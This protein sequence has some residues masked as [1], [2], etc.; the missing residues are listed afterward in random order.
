MRRVLTLLLL[1]TSALSVPAAERIAL[2]IGNAAYEEAPLKNPVNDARAMARRLGEL[3][4]QVTKLEDASKAQMEDA[5]ASFEGKLGPQ[6]SALFYYAGHG[7]QVRGRNYLIPVDAELG[8]ERRARFEAVDVGDVTEAMEY[9]KSQVNFVILDACRNNP[10]ER[11]WRG[12]G[13]GLVAVDAAR[14]TLIAYATAPGSVAADGDGENGLYTES[15]LAALKTPGLS[16][17]EVFKQ[18][19]AKVDKESSGQQTPW[20]SSSLTGNF[21]FNAPVTV[22]VQQSAVAPTT[23][24]ATVELTFWNDVKSSGNTAMFEAYLR[25]YPTGEFVDL[26]RIQMESL[27]SAAKEPPATPAIAAIEP[28]PLAVATRDPEIQ[29]RERIAE[30]LKAA[31]ADIAGLRLTSPK[32]RN[33]V[34]KYREVLGLEA[35]S[36][37]ALAGLD[38]VVAKYIGLAEK[39]ASHSRKKS[40]LERAE[41]V[42]P[43]SEA[44]E[45]ARDRLLASSAQTGPQGTSSKQASFG[46]SAMVRINGGCYQMGSPASET[47]RGDDEGRHRVCVKDFSLAKHELS[48][49]A[50]KRFVTAAGYR[51]EAERGDGCWTY[52]NDKWEERAGR[53]WRNPGFSQSDTHPVVCVSWNDATAYVT[54][55]SRQ[56]GKRFRLPTE[57]EW[58]YAVRA[59][60]TTPFWTGRCVS[61][62]QVHYNGN[63]EYSNCGAK[64]GQYRR[65]TVPVG[66]LP[67]NPWGLHEIL[68]N[69]WEWTCSAYKK[70]YD[71]SE[72]RC[73]SKGA[74][75]PRSLRG[76]SWTSHPGGVRSADRYGGPADNRSNSVG[77][78][79]AQD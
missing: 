66:S 32:G 46:A 68:G 53:D 15:L 29:K 60:T 75:V 26:A 14:G 8:S 70:S 17:E 39:S 20:E 3:G 19:R 47:D 59:G 71:G 56:T 76:G 58:E 36:D 35:E 13:R 69:V 27:M 50:F 42:V 12:K 11:R 18:V 7:I 9:A 72:Y 64:T 52:E 2:V 77:F 21:V 16:A 28:Q 4:F 37:Q 49:G 63:Y 67:A 44:V 38:S 62:R 1:I 5:I 41:K 48:V 61:T 55:L 33:A 51:T 78:R 54:W 43:G 25:K 65:R 31:D 30:L 74:S 57:A 73:A 23:T 40:Y 6:K 10:F 22:T 45:A 34:E 79:L 24:N